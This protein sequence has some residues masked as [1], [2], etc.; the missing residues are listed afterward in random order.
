MSEYRKKLIEAEYNNLEPYAMKSGDTKG[1]KYKE[2]PPK[3]RTE[4]QRDRDRIIHSSAFRRLEYKT[5]VFVNHEGDY[6]RTRLTHTIEVAQIARTI[7]VALRL[8]ETLTEAISLAHDIGHT[9]FGHAGERIL[10]EFMKDKGG[11]EHNIQGLRVVD[12]LEHKYPE[13]PGLNLCYETRE[14][15]IKHKTSYDNPDIPEEFNPDK[16]ATLEAQIVNVAD[17]IAYNSHDIDDG[18]KSGLIDL[19][20]IVDSVPLYKK[21]FEKTSLIN[22]RNMRIYQ[23]LRDLIGLLIFDAIKH[24]KRMIEKSKIESVEDVREAPLIID[25]SPEM[26]KKHKVLKEFLYNN[27]YT[28]YRVIKMQEKA[29]R[30][31]SLLFKVYLSDLRQLPPQ[32]YKMLDKYPPERVVCDYIAGMT[33]RYAQDEYAKLFTPYTRM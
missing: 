14:G 9:P 10:H 17:E 13:F 24:A 30:Y 18:L 32:F 2:P 11:F 31:I 26:R 19:E 12:L 22:D 23:T 33:D 8:N 1:R 15:I 4:F 3:F 21:L 16:K 5:Q 7:A 6:Y 27:L 29:K 25:F 20:Q 28:H